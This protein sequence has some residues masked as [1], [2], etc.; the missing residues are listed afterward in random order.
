MLKQTPTTPRAQPLSS[1]DRQS[2]LKI[3]K[4]ILR[5]A[6]RDIQAP[7]FMS[8]RKIPNGAFLTPL[9]MIK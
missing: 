8:W 1:Y 6:N 2:F 9:F 3:E 4:N 5:Q 7:F